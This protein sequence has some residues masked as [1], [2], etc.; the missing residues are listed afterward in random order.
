LV[1]TALTAVCVV[2]GGASAHGITSSATAI[3]TKCLVVP[4]PLTKVLRSSLAFS[5]GGQLFYARA[6]KSPAV[7]RV[8]FVSAQIRSS[9]L[10]SKRPI[11]TWAVDKLDATATA[12]PINATAR[13][14]SDLA[15]P[16][17][18]ALKLTMA[19]PGAKA[20][21]ACVTKLIR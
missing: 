6:V 17:N 20:S 3:R 2:V 16:D 12:S 18:G 1:A 8:Y 13:S 10:G 15:T 21:Q 9:Q 7:A 4:A 14:Y 19:T 11:G 5:S